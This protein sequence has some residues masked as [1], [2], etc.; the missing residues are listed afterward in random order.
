MRI[1]FDHGTPAPLR[2]KLV[3]H[4]VATAYEIGWADLDNGSLLDAAE[5]EFD[6]LIT[7]DQSLRHQQ[8]LIG[9]KLS[10]LV[11]ST[12]SWPKIE[13]QVQRLVTALNV[14]RP[15]ELVLLQFP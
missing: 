11:L 1:L 15:G 8:N 3:G 2:R 13:P 9:R 4:S 5:A 14:L 10:I 6:I 12:T 7:T